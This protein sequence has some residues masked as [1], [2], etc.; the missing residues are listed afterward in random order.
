MKTFAE[1]LEQAPACRVLIAPAPGSNSK[2]INNSWLETVK[3]DLLRRGN[4]VRY[5]EGSGEQA[6]KDACSAVKN[7]QA[8]MLMQGDIPLERFYALLEE[9]GILEKTPCFASL[10]EDRVRNKLFLVA[11]TYIHDFPGLKEKIAF[12]NKMIEL[13]GILGMETPKIAVLSAIETVNPAIPSTAE[14]AVLSKMSQRGQ[15]NALVEGPLDIDALA[16]QEAAR[17]K[18]VDSPVPGDYDAILG[19]DIETAHALSQAFTFIGRYPTAGILLGTHKPVIIHP[20]FIPRENKAVE[21]AI[22]ALQGGAGIG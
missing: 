13:A 16:K 2:G 17:L 11:D 3:E 21:V 12:V 1:I 6:V 10:F 7:G 9:E 8:D 14:A 15:F 20:G 5:Q 19:P 18:G 4:E 22:H